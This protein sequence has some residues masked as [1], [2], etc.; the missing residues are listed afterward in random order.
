[1]HYVPLFSKDAT[2]S[3]FYNEVDLQLNKW[4]PHIKVFPQDNTGVG[5]HIAKS[6]QP[7]NWIGEN[8]V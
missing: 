4:L 8:E 1:M 5:D 6:A 3:E 2:P 7:K